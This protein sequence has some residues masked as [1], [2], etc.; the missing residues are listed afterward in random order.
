[1]VIEGLQAQ[2]AGLHDLLDGDLVHRGGAGQFQQ[3]LGKDLLGSPFLHLTIPFG[4]SRP[5]GTILFRISEVPDGICPGTSL[6]APRA[7]DRET[8]AA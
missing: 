1:M 2:P 7:P 4:L 8:P 6:L 3:R 5:A